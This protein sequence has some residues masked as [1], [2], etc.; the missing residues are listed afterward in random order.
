MSTVAGA[1]GPGRRASRVGMH[2]VAREAGVSVAT[3]SNAINRPEMVSRQLRDRVGVAIDKL[4]F[5]PN[6]AARSLRT[7]RTASLGAVVFDLANPFFAV[8]ARH[9]ANVAHDRGY[10]LT[11]MSTDQVPGREDASLDFLIRH[12]VSGVVVTTA[13]PDLDRLAAVHD[14]GV[15]VTLLAQEST[16]PAIGSVHLDDDAGMH[17]IVEHLLATGRRRFGFVDGPGRARQHVARRAA[18]LRVLDDAGLDPAAHL[19]EV[20]APA[21]DMSGGRAAVAEL[22]GRA[23]ADLDA[24]V[25]INDYT[26]IGVLLGLQEAGLT[27]PDDIAV[28]GFDDI[29]IAELLAV[30]L[31]TIRQPMRELGEIAVSQ[32]VDACETGAPMPHRVLVP[33]LIARASTGA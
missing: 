17:L 2:D 12:G 15:A 11:V 4:G 26:A 13:L 10:A 1:R 20:V 33:E 16:H 32:L 7:G 31:T 23:G 5:I 21:P 22:L 6:A 9:M 28:T 3:V 29:E 27:V 8:V 30:P 25:C 18:L 14:S 24:I 19:T